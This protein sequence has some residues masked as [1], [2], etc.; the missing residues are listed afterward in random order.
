MKDGRRRMLRNGHE[1]DVG[2]NKGL[3]KLCRCARRNWAKCSHAWYFNF[4]WQGKGYRF[5][6]DRHVGRHIDSK[7]EAEALADSIRVAIRADQFQRTPS[8]AGDPP[9]PLR[10]A[11]PVVRSTWETVAGPRARR[12]GAHRRRRWVSAQ[13]PGRHRRC[14]GRPVRPEGCRFR[15]RR[16]PRARN[17]RASTAGPCGVH[18]Q[19]LRADAQVAGA[20]GRPEGPSPQPMAVGGHEPPSTQVSATEPSPR[21]RRARRKGQRQSC[22]R[23]A[24]AALGR[25]PLAPAAHHRRTRNGVQRGELLALRWADVDLE[26]GELTVRA[27]TD[28]DQEPAAAASVA[29]ASSRAGHDPQRP[30]RQRVASWR[31]RVRQRGGRAGG[32][33]EDCL[34]D[35]ACSGPTDTSRRI[36]GPARTASTMRAE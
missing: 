11:C 26:K 8:P 20:V 19:P 36:G 35:S 17:R 32:R 25:Q 14:R 22:W 24:A 29:S 10:A 12:Q 15:H 34:A 4:A 3:R 1:V 33:P 30:R 31:V 21:P 9:V 18:D 5:S 28:E 27:E 2:R 16:R 6:L 7:S 13:A 23:G